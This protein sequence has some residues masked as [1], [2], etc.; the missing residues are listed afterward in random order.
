MRLKLPYP[1]T[2]NH[3]FTVAR[4]RKILSKKGRIYREN[5]KI[6]VLAQR[7]L[8]K[9]KYQIEGDTRLNVFI[10]VYTP[11]RRKRDLDNLPK[12][13]LDALQYAEVFG[14]DSQ[15]DELTLK[16]CEVVKGGKVEIEI[17]KLN[18]T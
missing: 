11:D 12:G 17:T 18:S 13:I 5:A 10:E 14:D 16:R 6:E 7:L 15:I 9:D 2:N 8:H 3:Y 1:P 4:G